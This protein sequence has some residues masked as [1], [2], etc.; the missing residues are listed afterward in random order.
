M[1]DDLNKTVAQAVDAG[2]SRLSDAIVARQYQLMPELASK[3]G[4]AGREK[5]LQDA[6]YHLSYLA[7][8]IAAALPAMFSD[9]VAWAKVMLAGRGIPASDLALNLEC[10]RHALEEALP[11]EMSAIASQY[12]EAGL[13]QLPQ[14]PSDLPAFIQDGDPSA[15]LAK[16]YLAALLRGERHVASRLILDAVGA[17]VSV[18]D[19]YLNVFQRSQ[20]E[21]GRLWQ[22]NRVSVAQEH[23]CTAATQL[24]MSQLYSRIFATEKNGR[25]LVA[26]CVGGDLHEIGVRMVSDFFEMDGWDTFYLG[27]NVPLP[28]IVRT[29][30]ERKADVVA[31]SATI[32]YHAHKVAEVIAALRE[33]QLTRGVKILVGGY[34]FN[35]APDLWRQS[36]ADAFARDAEEAIAVANRL[37]GVGDL[38]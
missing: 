3:Y 29:V 4:D 33:G 20:Y 24:I 23:Y 9:Y 19:V 22:T 5:C 1:A 18:K 25:T 15:D 26:T 7:E 17:G 35:L 10:I 8:S 28:S 38:P 31:I 12:I 13:A 34:P 2:R 32:A 14:L 16:Q 30:V 6:H 36:G 21:I 37:V 11:Q 27:A